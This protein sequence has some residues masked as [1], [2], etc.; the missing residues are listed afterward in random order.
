MSEKKY[1]EE[2]KK[3]AMNAFDLRAADIVMK[4][5]DAEFTV[6]CDAAFAEKIKKV[7]QKIDKEAKKASKDSYHPIELSKMLGSAL[8]ML[9]GDGATKRIFQGCLPDPNRVSDAIVFVVKS[10]QEY[11]IREFL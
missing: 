8:D 9:L 11:V 1:S 4:L 5:G 7:S 6:H 3:K 10:Y 2:T